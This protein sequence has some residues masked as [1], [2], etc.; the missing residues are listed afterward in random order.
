MHVV[1]IMPIYPLLLIHWVK[2]R[3]LYSRIVIFEISKKLLVLDTNSYLSDLP[4]NGFWFQRYIECLICESGRVGAR[5]EPCIS[6]LLCD[7]LPRTFKNHSSPSWSTKSKQSQTKVLCAKRFLHL[8][9]LLLMS[10]LLVYICQVWALCF[11]QCSAWPSWR[12][13]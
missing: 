13:H 8:N 3:A 11:G 10:C 6:I 5:L 9:F 12:G 1:W 7:I 4:K 2:N